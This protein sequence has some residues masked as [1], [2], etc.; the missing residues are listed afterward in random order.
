MLSGP[1]VL[2]L[3][4]PTSHL[5]LE[6]IMSLNDGLKKFDQVFLMATHD[7]ALIDTTANRIVEMTPRGIIDR[8]M[9]FSE[10]VANEEVKA[11]REELYEDA[12]VLMY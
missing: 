3:D 6:A 4:D 1:N 8:R 11:L 9:P 7:F 10:Y 5:D 12:R 2:I